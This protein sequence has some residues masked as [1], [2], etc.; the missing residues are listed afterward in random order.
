MDA[1]GTRIYLINSVTI[2][3]C[4]RQNIRPETDYVPLS[5][6]ASHQ[7]LL[8]ICKVSSVLFDSF[9]CGGVFGHGTL[10]S[11]L[12]HYVLLLKVELNFVYV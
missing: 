4:D 1:S 11:G 5:A 10:E 8:E 6:Q 12:E 3:S 9:R 2:Y 7:A